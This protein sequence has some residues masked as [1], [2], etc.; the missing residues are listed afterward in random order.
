MGSAWTC[1]ELA[2][3]QGYAFT[4]SQQA[5][6]SG[7]GSSGSRGELVD[8]RDLNGCLVVLFEEDVAHALGGAVS[9]DVRCR[10]QQDLAHGVPGDRGQLFF[11]E[12]R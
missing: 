2:A 1:F 9:D 6:G 3:Q 7:V 10:L 4:Q 12:F 5:K 8:H 11:V